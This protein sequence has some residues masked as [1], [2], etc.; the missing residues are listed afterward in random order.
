MNF[1]A[2]EI[3]D[4]TSDDDD[5]ARSS[6]DNNY[7]RPSVDEYIRPTVD[8][9]IRP[10]VDEYIRPTVDEYIRPPDLVVREQLIPTV[11]TSYDS[12]LAQVSYHTT[13]NDEQRDLYALSESDI[14]AVLETSIREYN[15]E[16]DKYCLEIYEAEKKLRENRFMNVRRVIERIMRFDKTNIREYEELLN[17][18]TL[19][20]DG[21]TEHYVVKDE[22]MYTRIMFL[23]KSLRITPGE[24]DDLKSFI[25]Y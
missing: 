9:Y 11:R 22:V 17:A 14:E 23:L 19:Y 24:Y 12:E 4:L 16:M 6:F 25:C 20:E 5:Y 10:S 18:F 13:N 8:E 15:A 21:Y 2:D 7:V 1:Y 3:I